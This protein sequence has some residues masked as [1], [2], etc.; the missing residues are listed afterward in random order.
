MTSIFAS[1]APTHIDFDS[2][3]LTWL[4]I[5]TCKGD[6]VSYSVMVLSDDNEKCP[7]LTFRPFDG[8]PA[9]WSMPHAWKGERVEMCPEDPEDPNSW[10]FESICE[11]PEEH[12]FWVK[13]AS[14][15]MAL[16]FGW[17]AEPI[18]LEGEKLKAAQEWLFS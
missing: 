1:F 8:R 2:K 11:S 4:P 12:L 10:C 17:T 15:E 9:V 18:I 16:H 5:I 13:K 7:V 14:D 3:P 6:Q